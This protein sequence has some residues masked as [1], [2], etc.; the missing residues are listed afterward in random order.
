VL[1]SLSNYKSRPGLG[2]KIGCTDITE[3]YSNPFHLQLCCVM[4]I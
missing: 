2:S 4:T 3:L 1:F